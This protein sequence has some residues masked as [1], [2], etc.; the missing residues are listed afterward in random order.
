[1][2]RYTRRRALR[3]SVAGPYSREG[4]R[5]P[6]DLGAVT[7]LWEAFV[8]L[9]PPVEVQGNRKVK[10]LLLSIGI[11]SLDYPVCYTVFYCPANVAP[12]GFLVPTVSQWDNQTRAW[13]SNWSSS[14]DPNQN[15]LASGVIQA[16]DDCRVYWSGLRTLNSGD[17]IVLALH[18]IIPGASQVPTARA[19]VDARYSICYS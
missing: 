3:R 14:Y 15:V 2:R 5:F 11:C 8:T 6:V 9:V 18:N 12:N 10:N 4:T 19:V 17:R 7:G 16:P 13:V 1:M